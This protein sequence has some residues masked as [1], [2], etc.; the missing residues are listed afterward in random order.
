MLTDQLKDLY[1]AGRL[2]PFIGAGV[3]KSVSWSNG[4]KRNFRGPSWDE[5]IDQAARELGAEPPSLLRLRGTDLQVLEYFKLKRGNFSSLVYW[6]RDRLQPPDEALK[7]SPV[8]SQLVKLENCSRFYTTNYDDFLE[9]AFR[10]AGVEVNA[11]VNEG[12]M[13]KRQERIDVVKFHGDFSD[14]DS[15]VFS[16]S[17]YQE[18]LQLGSTLD[19]LIKSDLLNRAALFLGYSFRDPNVAYLFHLHQHAFGNL[20]ESRLNRRAYIVL[21]DPSDFDRRLFAERNIEVLPVSGSRIEEEMADVLAEIT[22]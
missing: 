5:V 7:N 20:P 3:S 17:Q 22:S 10:L 16:E 8:L 2:L 4:D 18:R 9:R 14:P 11:V 1:S 12:H 15:M 21:P 19:H 6:L 13:N